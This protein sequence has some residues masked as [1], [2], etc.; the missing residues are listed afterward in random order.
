[1]KCDCSHEIKRCFLLGRKA[2]TKKRQCIKK[3]RHHFA[4]K[5]PYSQYSQSDDSS[6]NHV[7]LWE[8]D[9]KEGRAPKNW[10][11]WTVMLK[12]SESPL[13]GKEINPVNLRGNQPWI[14]T[15]RTNAE[16]ETP[17]FWSPDANSWPIGKVPDAGN[18][19]GQKEKR[20]Q[21]M[22]WLG[23]ITNTM[24]MNLDKLWEI[25]RDREAW[26]A[27]VHGVSKSWR[28]LGRQLNNATRTHLL[29]G[30]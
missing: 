21:R 28:W 15:G 6:H 17:V 3:Q 11:L 12:T 26:S 19:W 8:L 7:Q 29:T 24:D 27:A 25:V 10:C 23:G 1:M 22:R 16:A 20:H 13:D 5:H 2:M 14:L 30:C 18:D 4:N 9:H